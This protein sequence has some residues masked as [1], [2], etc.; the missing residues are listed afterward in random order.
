MEIHAVQ[1]FGELTKEDVADIKF[2]VIARRS[3]E[4]KIRAQLYPSLLAALALGVLI[5]YLTRRN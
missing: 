3:T 1:D 4:D 5:G 2:A